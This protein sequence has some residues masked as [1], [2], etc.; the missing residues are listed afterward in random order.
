MTTGERLNRIIREEMEN[1]EISGAN[2][3]I[4]R[5]GRVLFRQSYG[6]ADIERD[7]PM[8]ED[9]IFRLFSMTKLVTGL[10][11]MI[12][13]ER[14]V[15]DPNEPVGK[16]LSTFRD[17]KF[18]D[19]NGTLR[20]VERPMQIRDLLSMTSGLV[21]PGTET[22]AERDMEKLFDEI[23]DAQEKGHPLPTV[24]FMLR[25]G[26]LPLAFTPGARWQYGTSADVCGAVIERASGMRFGEFLRKEIFAPL[27][28]ED[29]G[30]Y[31][32]QEKMD[33]FTQAYEHRDATDKTPASLQALT[34][35]HLG[36]GDYD[37]PPAF[38]SGGAGLV[39]TI[40]DMHRFA[41][42]LLN[43]GTAADG[44]RILSPRTARLFRSN[45]LTKEQRRS[46]NWDTLVGHGYGNFNRVL[47]DP[48]QAVMNA[49]AGE[50]GW[51]GWLGTYLSVDPEDGLIFLYFIQRA[52]AGTTIPT[53]KL[54]AVAYTLRDHG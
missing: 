40:G 38:E 54:K 20:P 33:R 45:A 43:E 39:S 6:M 52:D 41:V 35:R 14:G 37:S 47:L 29:T 13:Y 23:Y 21:Y 31:V 28:M 49:P 27:H 3:L 36:M 1:K 17:M 44:T 10:A 9:S 34:G 42:M 30:F 50:F 48:G 15:I 7:V 12:L 5:R 8:R 53:R 4:S 46:M 16:Y 11:A 2:L 51:D 26:E 19:E 32:P 25:I 18:Y 22:P 24:G